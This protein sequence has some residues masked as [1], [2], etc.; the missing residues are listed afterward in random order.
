M[1]PTSLFSRIRRGLSALRF[2]NRWNAPFGYRELLSLA[3]PLVLSNIATTIMMFTDRVFLSR[4]SLLSIAAAFPSGIMYFFI[5]SFF[6]GLVTYTGVFAAQYAGA[7]KPRRAAASLWQGL[8]LGIFVGVALYSLFFVSGRI[9]ALAGHSP[10]LVR[11]ETVYFDTLL[12]VTPAA[13]AAAAMSSFLAS[14]GRV[15]LVM[16]INLAATALNIPLDY[17]L[18][19]GFRVFGLEC[20]ALGIF[21]AAL[22]TDVSALFAAVLFA[23]FCFNKSMDKS[24]GV[25][26]VWRTDFP[27][28]GKLLKYGY[29]SGIQL[30]LE[31]FGMA[32]FAFAMS[33][34]D[35][36]TLAASNIVFSIEGVTFF[37]ILGMGQAVSIMVGHAV[38]R[39]RP[40]DGSR[41]A[42]S[43]IVLSSIYVFVLLLCFFSFP[44]F[45]LGVFMPDHLD[46]AVLGGVIALGTVMLRF[47]V[48]YSFFDG[49]YVCC[50]GVMRGSGDV[51]FPM[52]AMGFWSL[53]GLIVPIFIVFHFQAASVY[54]LWTC[55]VSWV[56][57]LS[58][59][60][61]WRFWSRR[62]MTKRV[63]EA[64]DLSD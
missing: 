21:G 8:R 47:V 48:L 35:E 15:R 11:E 52:L 26:S 63:I 16:W 30:T 54:T 19:F 17:L 56:I 41:A 23:C 51:L 31:I 3:L 46:P 58:L 55:M 50:F 59:T 42:V 27:L 45:F 20:P 64:Y 22:A 4:H 6:F 43:G 9:F 13:L 36:L 10:E 37:P 2:K 57:L 53:F 34:M 62:W 18:I 32:F 28:L 12:W 14:V 40:E 25:W 24:F 7:G 38:G 39:G 29:L 60:F 61:A 44:G 33:R 5:Q 1:P 49:F